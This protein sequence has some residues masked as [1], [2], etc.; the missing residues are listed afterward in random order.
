[1]KVVVGLGNYGDKYAY[2]YHNM[3]F[4]SVE[5]LADKLSLKFNERECDSMVAVGYR[6]GE[7][8]VLA[9][10]LTY[11]NLS[12]VAVK[13]LMGKYKI[14][15][16]DLI[17]I[18]DDIDIDG[19]SVRVRMKGSA[20]T[21]NGMRNIIERI[22]S[23]DFPRVRVGIGPKPPFVPIADYVLSEVPKADRQKYFDAFSVAADEVIKLI[24]GETKMGKTV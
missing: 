14:E 24:D 21:H 8:I 16:K 20:G 12:G 5:A 17:V 22:G 1:M 11:M 4:L 10:P 18:F 3:G 2:T 13:Q 6:K 15:P 19:A 9:K 23:Q 7:K